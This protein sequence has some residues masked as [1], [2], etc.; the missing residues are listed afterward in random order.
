MSQSS[1]NSAPLDI[2]IGDVFAS[3]EGGGSIHIQEMCQSP[4][5]RSLDDCGVGAGAYASPI[6]LFLDHDNDGTPLDVVA[7][8]SDEAPGSSSGRWLRSTWP[9][10]H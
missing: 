5:D 6:V 9:R 10:R 3:R 2:S 1:T 4:T 7:F 8:H